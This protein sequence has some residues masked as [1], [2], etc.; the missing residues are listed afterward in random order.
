MDILAFYMNKEQFIGI[1]T[2]SFVVRCTGIIIFVKISTWNN[3]TEN[4]HVFALSCLE[5]NQ[6]APLRHE[7]E[8]QKAMMAKNGNEGNNDLVNFKLVAMIALVTML[9]KM[10][11]MVPWQPSNL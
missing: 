11:G 3:A 1:F 4:D 9:M 7:E 5:E 6:K 10:T 8:N 2:A